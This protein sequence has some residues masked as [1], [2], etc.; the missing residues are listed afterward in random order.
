MGANMLPAPLSL[1]PA[2]EQLKRPT[3]EMLDITTGKKK[4]VDLDANDAVNDAIRLVRST[5]CEA[6]LRMAQ[7]GLELSLAGGG[8]FFVFF[9]GGFSWMT[10]AFKVRAHLSTL[11]RKD[12]G[13]ENKPDVSRTW[14]P[15]SGSPGLGIHVRD[16]PG[17]LTHCRRG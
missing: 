13:W 14:I 4:V 11:A 2:G 12:R 1:R 8:Y 15:G 17:T 9:R 16:A 5:G 10:T 3:T 7:V 6:S